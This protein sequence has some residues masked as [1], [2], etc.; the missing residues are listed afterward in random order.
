VYALAIAFEEQSV[1]R[2]HAEDAADLS[3]N[4]DSSPTCDFGFLPHGENLLLFSLSHFCCFLRSKSLAIKGR[5]PV[6]SASADS[7]HYT[8]ASRHSRAGLSYSAA[9]RLEQ[10]AGGN[11]LRPRDIAAPLFD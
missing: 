3:R 4:S 8:L 5:S 9:S 6:L 7:I 1:S 11:R 10:N 2:F